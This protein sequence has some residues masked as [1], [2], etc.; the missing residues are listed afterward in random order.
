MSNVFTAA[1]T[2]FAVSATL[3]STFDEAGYSDVGM[4][5]SL[6][7]EITGIPAIGAEYTLVTHNPV[8]DRTTVKRKGSVDFG[9]GI[10][11]PMALDN[12]DA[13][14]NIMRDFAYGANVDDSV[15]VK[16]TR[17]D[18]SVRYFTCQVM[19]FRE[20]ADDVNSISAAET[21]IEIDREIVY[22]DAP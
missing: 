6:V 19:M 13:G 20:S 3:P 9:S 8:G 22:V 1:G 2:L 10:T 21:Q 4:V 14:Q 5:Y 16:I 7:G 18:G 17:P 15:A 11:L 12:S